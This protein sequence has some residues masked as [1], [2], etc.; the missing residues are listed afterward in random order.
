MNSHEWKIHRILDETKRVYILPAR[1]NS[2]LYNQLELYADLFTQKKD[3]KVIRA[4]DSRFILAT[5]PSVPANRALEPEN[6]A[7]RNAPS[8]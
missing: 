3:I 2:K 4:E 1:G 5:V 7:T 6:M 8:G